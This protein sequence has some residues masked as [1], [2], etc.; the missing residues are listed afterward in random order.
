MAK[1]PGGLLA[2]LVIFV[3]DMIS[4]FLLVSY[5]APRYKKSLASTIRHLYKAK[6]KFEVDKYRIYKWKTHD[7]LN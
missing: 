3:S 5:K 4:H 7:S 2:I 6:S 1:D